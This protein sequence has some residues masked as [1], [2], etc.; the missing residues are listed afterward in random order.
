MNAQMMSLRTVDKG[1]LKFLQ[2]Q[3]P[4]QTSATETEKMCLWVQM[5]EVLLSLKGSL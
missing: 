4:E 1:I 3:A 5:F 2:H